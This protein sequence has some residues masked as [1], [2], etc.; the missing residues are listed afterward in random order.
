MPNAKGTLFSSLF[1]LLGRL[2]HRGEPNLRVAVD[3]PPHP[4]S[5]LLIP[6]VVVLLAGISLAIWLFISPRRPALT[7]QQESAVVSAVDQL[8]A[9]L[10]ANPSDVTLIGVLP[11]ANDPSSRVTDAV[12]DAISVSGLYINKSGSVAEKIADT[13]KLDRTAYA[14]LDSAVARGRSLGLHA[15]LFGTV[16]GPTLRGGTMKIQIHYTL[17]STADGLPSDQIVL[18][19]GSASSSVGQSRPLLGAMS[20]T[21]RVTAWLLATFALPL[22]LMPALRA[23]VRRRSNLSNALTLAALTLSSALFAHFMLVDYM[24][25][26]LAV[27]FL[28]GLGT[29]GFLTTLL[30]MNFALSLES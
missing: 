14:D 4:L 23:T 19:R 30:F 17:A 27:L 25:G 8:V 10:V 29:V 12:R 5:Y 9:Q 3:M 24:P 28:L 22:V 18:A 26:L 6:I 21:Y 16:D 15:V 20:A 7:T 1:S 13:L 11:L 2:F